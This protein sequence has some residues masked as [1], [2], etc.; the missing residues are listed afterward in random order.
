MK[1]K[2]VHNSQFEQPAKFHCIVTMLKS[3]K[4]CLDEKSKFL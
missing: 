3:L 1:N 4:S 2:Y